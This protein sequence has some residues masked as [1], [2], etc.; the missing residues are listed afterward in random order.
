M[1]EQKL[2]ALEKVVGWIHKDLEKLLA[3]IHQE[4]PAGPAGPEQVVE[5]LKSLAAEAGTETA[6]LK[7]FSSGCGHAAPGR[8]RICGCSS[9][10]WQSW[11][12]LDELRQKIREATEQT[13]QTKQETQQ[14]KD[15]EAIERALRPP[16]LASSRTAATSALVRLRNTLE[17]TTP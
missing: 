11:G 1:T 17:A 5:F 3:I 13:Q 16:L 7:L 8:G 15:L 4:F 12:S 9:A 6:H 2:K 14:A 10:T